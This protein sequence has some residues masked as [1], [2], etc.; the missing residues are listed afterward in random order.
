[1][2]PSCQRST[3]AGTAT[4]SGPTSELEGDLRLVRHAIRPSRGNGRA[5]ERKVHRLALDHTPIGQHHIRRDHRADTRTLTHLPPLAADREPGQHHDEGQ[6]RPDHVQREGLEIEAFHRVDA[7]AVDA[8]QHARDQRQRQH[9][10]GTDGAQVEEAF[11][12]RA[13]LVRDV[14]LALLRVEQRRQ[15]H[16]DQIQRQHRLV[17]LGPEAVAHMAGQAAGR[18]DRMDDVRPGIDQ[19]RQ[20]ARRDDVLAEQQEGQRRREEHEARQREQEVELRHEVAA[21][22]EP[23]QPRTRHRIL[24]PQDL[25]HPAAPAHA[26]AD[27]QHEPLGRQARGERHAR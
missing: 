2:R 21:A 19:D 24:D 7:E 26:L 13:A 17:D 22:L 1:M 25:D 10:V 11:L 5:A 20:R 23:A 16:R 15:H 4:H 12:Q 18:A 27:V 14:E 3:S 6:H 8:G 9:Q